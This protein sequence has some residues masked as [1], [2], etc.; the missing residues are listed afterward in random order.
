MARGAPDYHK[1]IYI[2]RGETYSEFVARADEALK[3]FLMVYPDVAP[4]AAGG[5]AHLVDLATGLPTPYTSPAGYFI[6]F[7]E[8]AF[9]FDGFARIEVTFDV[10]PPVYIYGGPNET[11]HQYEQIV[12]ADSRYFDPSALLPHTIDC[13]VKNYGDDAAPG[14]VQ[15]ALALRKLGSGG[16]TETKRIRCWGCGLETRI[17]IKETYWTCPKCGRRNVYPLLGLIGDKFV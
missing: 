11:T 4:L 15:V 14:G 5:S 6:D 12:F 10:L 2:R 7:R 17:P 1:T 8:W 9:F 16:E 13:V 3:I